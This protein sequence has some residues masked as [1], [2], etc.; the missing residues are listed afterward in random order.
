MNLK[1]LPTLILLM[2]SMSVFTQKL[3]VKKDII[4]IDKKEVSLKLI[5]DNVGTEVFYRL[6]DQNTGKIIV[7]VNRKSANVGN[8]IRFEWL[9]LSKD[10]IPYE[11]EVDMEY[12]SFTLSNKKAIA[13]FLM[14]K[15]NFF[16][17]TGKINHEAVNSFF[18]EK[19]YRASKDEF[20]ELVAETKK[21]QAL[22]DQTSG[23][24]IAIDPDHKEIFRGVARNL[25]PS[26]QQKTRL[27]DMREK[28][29][30]TYRFADVNTI[31]VVD[32][33]NYIIATI[34]QDSFSGEV[35]MAS[36][37]LT[38]PIIYKTDNRF[39]PTDKYKTRDFMVEAVRFL[40]LNG[41]ELGTSA[42]ESIDQ[43]NEEIFESA[44]IAYEE[45][46]AN[47]SNIYNQK[48]YVIDDKGTRY[49]G[50][51]T[52]VFED[53]KDPSD[54]MAGGT[55]INLGGNE[56]GKKVR[57][58]Y[59]NKNEKVRFKSFSSKND[60]RVC[61]FD[62]QGNESC[63]EGVKVKS[64]GLLATSSDLSLTG[65]GAK[66]MK[67]VYVTDNAIVFQES[68]SN[69]YYLK[70]N[71]REKAF[72]F[73]F[74]GLIKEDKKLLKLKEYLSGCDYIKDGYDESKFRDLNY[75]NSLVD[76]YNSSCSK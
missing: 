71:T 66:F 48:G 14:S 46:L 68:P 29:I 23:L 44:Q 5:D 51:L 28:M 56:I 20:D 32:L 76:Y 4:L 50:E 34:T 49:E 10:S 3:K 21:N 67:E 33:D 70:V 15:L 7:S 17:G 25:S 36:K 8:D 60:V 59:L 61:L 65:T 9:V 19:R 11:N 39:Y 69:K 72:D 73:E 63:Y 45:A 12:V 54:P 30:G 24:G 55:I 57:V 2:L 38:A 42:K 31:L 13:E 35:K 18:S 75:I 62:E 64:N 27:E 53:I 40:H 26:V 1:S 74:G 58:A 16:D 52:L 37:L 41:L 6:V 22:F 47:S 43:A